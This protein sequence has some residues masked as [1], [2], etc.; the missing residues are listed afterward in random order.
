MKKIILFSL[1]I[2]LS[3]CKSNVSIKHTIIIVDKEIINTEF[4]H[5]IDEA[6][7]ALISWYLYAYGNECVEFKTSTKCKL[8]KLLNIKNEC[9]ATHLEM[10]KK[11]FSKDI[12]A[13]YKLKK[14]PN[15]P[16]NSAIQNSI[17][18]I[19]LTRNN[20]KLSITYKIKGLNNSQE[21]SWNINRTDNYIIVNNTF[22]K[23]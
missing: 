15:L 5:K 13:V 10:L 12:L 8:L 3:S 20:N 4:A 22:Q 16:F 7:K 14:C 18:K 11:W 1:I 6:E 2:L 9:E 21:K 17:D 19:V 23:K